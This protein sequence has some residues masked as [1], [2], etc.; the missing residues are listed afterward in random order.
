MINAVSSS[1]QQTV[2]SGGALQSDNN[3][4]AAFQKPD[5]GQKDQQNQVQT[6]RSA[7]ATSSQQTS[8]QGDQTASSVDVYAAADQAKSAAESSGTEV[9]RGSALDISV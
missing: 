5:G 9:E 8:A 1:A 2:N 6:D 4:V 3:K 7:Q